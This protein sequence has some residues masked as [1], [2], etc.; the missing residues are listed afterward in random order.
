[1]A[2]P[3]TK[4]CSRCGEDKPADRDHFYPQTQHG[5]GVLQSQCRECFDKLSNS[6]EYRMLLREQRITKYRTMIEQGR[7]YDDDG[8]RICQ[9]CWRTKFANYFPQDPDG[10]D[11]R[12]ITCDRCL[13]KQREKHAS[14]RKKKKASRTRHLSPAEKAELEAEKHRERNPV[15]ILEL[16]EEKIGSGALYEPFSRIE[17]EQTCGV[18]ERDFEAGLKQ[19]VKFGKLRRHQET[20]RNGA[21]LYSLIGHPALKDDPAPGVTALEHNLGDEAEETIPTPARQPVP[22][23]EAPAPVPAP[24]PARPVTP[25]RIEEESLS[26]QML[27]KALEADDAKDKRTFIEAAL[28]LLEG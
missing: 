11:G 20:G 17:L 19:L 4:K 23:P 10:P 12:G 9:T 7:Y 26:D 14:K 13:K 21:T 16:I 24:A 3:N 6:H 2:K 28:K 22:K 1:M 25:A 15:R 5:P 18:G 8:K 27:W